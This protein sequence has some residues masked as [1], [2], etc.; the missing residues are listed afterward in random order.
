MCLANCRQARVMDGLVVSTLGIARGPVSDNLACIGY[1]AWGD[2]DTRRMQGRG[3]S[4]Q[5]SSTHS[6]R[7][8]TWGRGCPLNSSQEPTLG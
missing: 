7:C 6:L 1:V 5:K 8:L 4:P 3:S 2:I